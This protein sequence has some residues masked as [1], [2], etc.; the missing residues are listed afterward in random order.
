MA[1][2]NMEVVETSHQR[3]ENLYIKQLLRMSTDDCNLADDSPFDYLLPCMRL[4]LDNIA[5]RCASIDRIPSLMP[6]DPKCLAIESDMLTVMNLHV[7]DCQKHIKDFHKRKAL[8]P[9][10]Q[11]NELLRDVDNFLYHIRRAQEHL[12]GC[13]NRRVSL[14]AL[15]ESQ[16]SIQQVESGK[17]LSQLAYIYLPLAFS[18]SLFGMNIPAFQNGTITSFIITT[19]VLLICSLLFWLLFLP[20]QKAY[21]QLDENKAI[22]WTRCKR[23]VL[24]KTRHM[25]ERWNSRNT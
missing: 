10:Q 20:L 5:G 8:L 24:W 2:R 18:S 17:R 11:V 4:L 9:S 1:T 3:F 23:C 12:Q 15:E 22:V 7:E 16:K 21:R 19:V 14:L 6:A 25:R 13:L